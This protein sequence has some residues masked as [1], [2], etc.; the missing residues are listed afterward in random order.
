M[1]LEGTKLLLLKRFDSEMSIGVDF[2]I[3]NLVVDKYK[4]KLDIW[5]LRRETRF[6]FLFRSYVHGANGFLFLY[7]VN[8][9]ST[10]LS[11]D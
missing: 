2:W 10:L 5:D 7:D 9:K 4:I 1:S 11:I 6:R 3:K 8:R